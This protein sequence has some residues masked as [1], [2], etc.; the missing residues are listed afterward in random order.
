MTSEIVFPNSKSHKLLGALKFIFAPLM[1]MVGP[2]VVYGREHLPKEGGV[3]V[4]INHLS[5]SDPMIVQNASSR[6]IHFMAKSE[7][8]TI[9]ILKQW[10]TFWGG[11]PVKRGVPDRASIRLAVELAKAGRVVGIFPEGKLSED[12]KLQEIRE[13]AALII[14]MSE[15]P[16]IC[17][18][19]KNTNRIVPYGS[20]IPRPAFCKV[21]AHW[22][23]PR[24]FN[25]DASNEE[26]T[27]WI[28]AEFR[29]LIPE[30]PDN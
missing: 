11:F 30:P 17:L 15:V 16:V 29:R 14:R 19:I 25:K 18:G 10:M 2:C 7:L 8:F 23:E 20:L 9:P 4:L 3:I 13:G 24:S 22:G 12:G 5:D 6:G 21:T 28:E 1:F 26:I 27:S